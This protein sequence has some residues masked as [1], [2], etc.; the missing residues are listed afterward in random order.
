MTKI[1]RALLVDYPSW[2]KYASRFDFEGG[3]M[4][5]HYPC[6]ALT[7]VEL[8]EDRQVVAGDHAFVYADDF[9][10]D[11][12]PS[13]VLRILV[14]DWLNGQREFAV[15][16]KDLTGGVI[17]MRLWRG[18]EPQVLFLRQMSRSMEQVAEKVRGSTMGDGEKAVVLAM[19]QRFIPSKAPQDNNAG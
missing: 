13:Q 3:I 12:S 2:V 4:P 9:M 19:M 17:H 15:D 8:D 14:T 7:A 18:V 11:L 5:H 16:V 1:D 6:L 10:T